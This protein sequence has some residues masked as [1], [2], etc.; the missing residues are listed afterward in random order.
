MSVDYKD[1]NYIKMGLDENKWHW[2]KHTQ[3]CYA[4]LSGQ[5]C[6]S[7]TKCNYAHNVTEYMNAITKR[8]FILD[9]SIIR[10]FQR[11]EN[12]EEPSVKKRRIF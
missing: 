3:A 12:N 5:Q 8:K 1:Y 9:E 7:G 11:L 4:I 6:I 10:G 2:Y